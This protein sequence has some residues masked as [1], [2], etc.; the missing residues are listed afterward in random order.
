MI[1]KLHV[2]SVHTSCAKVSQQRGKPSSFVFEEHSEMSKG[3]PSFKARV[4]MTDINR[5]MVVIYDQIPTI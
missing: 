1:E 4:G 3:L 2:A 5:S